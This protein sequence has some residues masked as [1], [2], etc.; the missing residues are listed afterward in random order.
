MRQGNPNIGKEHQCNECLLSFDKKWL[1]TRHQNRA[2]RKPIAWVKSKSLGA[3]D[4]RVCSLQLASIYAL[5]KH[6]FFQHSEADVQAQYGLS[7]EKYIGGKYLEEF[8]K[9]IYRS[10]SLCRFNSLVESAL[11][12]RE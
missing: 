11:G 12:G 9:V 10:I 8:R 7:M 2:H 5:K 3:Y 1:L 6:V 4:C